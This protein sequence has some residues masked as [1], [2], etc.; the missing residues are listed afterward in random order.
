M[1]TVVAV[2]LIATTYHCYYG[3]YCPLSSLITFIEMTYT[4]T[5][6][7]CI[8]YIYIQIYVYVY[9]YTYI[10]TYIY[11]YIV[12]WCISVA[13]IPLEAF[14]CTCSSCFSSCKTRSRSSWSSSS[15]ELAT[16]NE[17]ILSVSHG[18]WSLVLIEFKG[19]LWGFH[20]ILWDFMGFNGISWDLMGFYGDLIEF[21]CLKG[22]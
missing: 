11:I 13:S 16:G 22:I 1:I 2:I 14:F 18:S 19:D 7:I 10:Y 3:Y 8:L 15:V 4:C 5:V 21:T 12:K 6:C 17:R 9:I 20:G